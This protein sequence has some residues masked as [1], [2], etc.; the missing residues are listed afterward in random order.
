MLEANP[1]LT[2]RDVQEILARTAQVFNDGSDDSLATNG[3]GL[4]HS[5]RYGFGI[6]NADEAVAASEKWVNIGKESSMVQEGR[7][8]VVIPD[9]RNNSTK[10]SL[11]F[12][13]GLIDF[14]TETVYLYIKVE[15]SSRGHLRIDLTSPSGMISVMTPGERP[16]AQQAGWMKFT[17]VR[18][19]DEDPNGE[20]VISIVDTTLGDVNDC[21]DYDN[22]TFPFSDSRNMTCAPKDYRMMTMFCSDGAFDPSGEQAAACKAFEDEE[23]C[24]RL[25]R[26]ETVQYNGRTGPEACCMCGGGYSPD[27]LPETIVEWKLVVYGHEISTRKGFFSRLFSRFSRSNGK[28]HQVMNSKMKEI[29]EAKALS[30]DDFGGIR[31]RS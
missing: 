27:E 24:D 23:L 17:S 11:F 2:W 31:R 5:N 10:L 6:V 19:W 8:P 28:H 4:T 25:K 9:S 12:D 29:R 16:E 3:A 18:F 22:Y 30:G 20:W 7:G 26:F 1:E 14:E 15:H 21:I 13:S